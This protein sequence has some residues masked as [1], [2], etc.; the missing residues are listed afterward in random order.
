MKIAVAGGFDG[1]KILRAVVPSVSILVVDMQVSPEVVDL[2]VSERHESMKVE[3]S[4]L[5]SGRIPDPKSRVV[6]RVKFDAG[7]DGDRAHRSLPVC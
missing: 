6:V 7:A 4:V 2:A 3:V 1:L 5:L